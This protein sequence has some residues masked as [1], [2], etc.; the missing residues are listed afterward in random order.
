MIKMEM[1]CGNMQ[2]EMRGSDDLILNE[3]ALAV[4]RMLT[5]LEQS[6]GRTLS[7]NLSYLVLSLL[8]QKDGSH[9]PPC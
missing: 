1:Q 5:A 4:I 3:L 9:L 6:D 7:E 8:A 2:L